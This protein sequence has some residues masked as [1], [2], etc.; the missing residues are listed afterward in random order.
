MQLI[1]APLRMVKRFCVGLAAVVLPAAAQLFQPGTPLPKTLLPPVIFLNGYQSS[2]SDVTFAGTFGSFDQFLQ[3]S[4]RVSVL[5]DNC[6]VPGK[7][8]IEVLGNSFATFLGTLRYADGSAVTQVDVVSH[9]MGGLIVRAYLA[10]MQPNGTFNP[11]ANPGI[12]KAVFLSSPNFGTYAAALL[13]SDAQTAE[14]QLGS[15]FNF[16]LATWNQGTDDLR[17]VDALAVAGNGGALLLNGQSEGDGVSSLTSSS[18]GFAEAGRTRI[19]PYCHISYSDLVVLLQPVAI[20]FPASSVCPVGAPGI[21]AGVNATDSNVLIVESFLNSTP[22]WQT[23]GQSPAQNGL[24]STSSGLL[25]RAK[26][27]SD[28]YVSFQDAVAGKFP[29]SIPPGNLTAYN[30]FVASGTNS[31]IADIISNPQIQLSTTLAAG[32]TTSVLLKPG[33]SIAAVIPAAALVTP[34][35]VAPGTFISIYGSALANTTAQAPSAPFPTVL[36]GTQVLVNGTAIP[37]QYVSPTQVNAVLPV[38]ISGLITVTVTATAG[39]NTV[40]VLTQ[41]AVPAI[42][43]SDGT[44]ASAINAVTGAVVTP[45]TPLHAGDYVSLYLTGLGA[46]VLGADSLQHASITPSVTVAGQTCTLQFAGL[47]PQF[48]GV[49]QINCQIP[50]GLGTNSA[51]P[52]IVTANGRASNTAA[53]ALQ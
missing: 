16:A 14:L 2:C 1:E 34:R 46:T 41:V 8:S 3:A 32:Y 30:E 7:P 39:Q 17:G 31:I 42:F 11:P 26:S 4:N 18:I 12:R 40:N 48:P 43:T 20:L 52:V 50:A 6:T 27:A 51:A 22:D 23:I 21:A 53:I 29:L 10:G 15:T 5:F 19:L 13:G 25:L 28:V 35:N 45:S 44:S 9:S 37:L 33:P 38:L 47:S 24:A 49:D 36:G